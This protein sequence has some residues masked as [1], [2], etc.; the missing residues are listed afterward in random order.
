M[1]DRA[2]RFGYGYAAATTP[3]VI[4]AAS[5]APFFVLYGSASFTIAVLS[6][7]V[8]GL[9]LTAVAY[10]SI[11]LRKHSSA[12]SGGTATALTQV[13]LDSVTPPAT[14]ALCQ[15]YTVAP[16]AGALV[17]RV[18]C[19]RRLSQA[20]TAAAAGIP[21]E[22]RFI[23]PQAPVILRGVAEGVALGFGVAPATAVTLAVEVSW[24]EGAEI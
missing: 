23:N 14:V 10:H 11:E 6:V 20:T 8:S 2:I 13:P 24:A 17:G 15:V 19:R 16:T 21:A 18:G 5:V 3:S 9:T 4:A 22:V 7:V 1:D 12:P